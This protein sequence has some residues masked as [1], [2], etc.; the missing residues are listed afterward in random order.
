MEVPFYST[1][2]EAIKELA[3]PPF[4][5]APCRQMSGL[6]ER[7]PFNAS[8][9]AILTSAV[10]HF[11]A[12]TMIFTPVVKRCQVFMVTKVVRVFS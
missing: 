11:V 12:V 4:L 3:Y 10:I 9:L 8:L 5:Q 6:L 2:E 1:F 7:Q